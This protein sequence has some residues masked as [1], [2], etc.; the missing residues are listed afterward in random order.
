MVSVRGIAE[1]ELVFFKSMLEA[2]RTRNTQQLAHLLR[3]LP[4]RIKEWEG[5]LATGELPPVLII[6]YVLARKRS[7]RDSRLFHSFVLVAC[8]HV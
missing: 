3:I 7:L 8:L 4:D 2:K 6:Q 5:D 1:S